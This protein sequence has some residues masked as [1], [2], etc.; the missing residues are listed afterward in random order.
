MGRAIDITGMR[1][2][3]MTAIEPLRSEPGQGVMWLTQCDCGNE[4]QALASSFRRGNHPSCIKC[5]MIKDRTGQ[6][7]GRL[8]AVCRWKS[9]KGHWSWLFTCDCG[10]EIVTRWGNAHSCGCLDTEN[11]YKHGMTGTPTYLSWSKAKARCTNPKNNRYESYGA[12][13]I[14]MCVRW[15][16]S[17]EC[18]Y[19]D[20]GERPEGTTIDRINNDGNYE[21]SN[22]RWANAV[23]QANNRRPKTCR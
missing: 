23:T 11:K 3:R 6:R 22:C 10:E 17:F 12:R 13:G 8:V 7:I 14:T 16:E 4:S 5:A 15:L 2:G 18:F 20:M 21:P 1:R 19:A 9:A